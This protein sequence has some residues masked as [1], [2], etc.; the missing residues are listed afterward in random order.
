M[1]T[2][3]PPTMVAAFKMSSNFGV[4]GYHVCMERYK[5]SSGAPVGRT[6]PNREVAFAE[7]DDERKQMIAD[8]WMEV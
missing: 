3:T 1:I 4:E 7:S 2:V 6:T 8:G 5:D